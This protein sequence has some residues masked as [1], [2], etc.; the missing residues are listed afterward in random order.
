MLPMI[1]KAIR[2]VR[3]IIVE[4]DAPPAT[5]LFVVEKPRASV[6]MSLPKS[7]FVDISIRAIAIQ[8]RLDTIDPSHYT[9]S[10]SVLCTWMGTTNFVSPSSAAQA[11]HSLPPRFACQ[12]T[13]CTWHGPFL[14]SRN[15][16][17]FAQ[18]LLSAILCSSQV[19][20]QAGRNESRAAATGM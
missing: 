6:G 3:R 13:L 14:L 8:P 10:V 1:L 7:M 20:P 19:L 2:V 16:S 9:T 4:R 5:I 15:L 11:L 12:G 17:P 18:A